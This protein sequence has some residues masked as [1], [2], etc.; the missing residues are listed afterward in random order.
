MNDYSD[1][2][3]GINGAI[4]SS[5]AFQFFAYSKMKQTNENKNNETKSSRYLILSKSE[6]NKVNKD[7]IMAAIIQLESVIFLSTFNNINLI[8]RNY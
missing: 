4:I 7:T 6:S 1:K 2:K 5:L 8:N 3:S